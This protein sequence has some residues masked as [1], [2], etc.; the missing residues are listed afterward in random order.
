[1]CIVDSLK[2]IIKVVYSLFDTIKVGQY[3]YY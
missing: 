3:N 1:M 2:S